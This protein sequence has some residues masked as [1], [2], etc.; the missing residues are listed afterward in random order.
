VRNFG[1]FAVLQE[2]SRGRPGQP[3]DERDERAIG[4]F[5]PQGVTPGDVGANTIS[6]DNARGKFEE[7]RFARLEVGRT[8]E[9]SWEQSEEIASLALVSRTGHVC[10]A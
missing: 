4:Y 7:I 8:R 5:L 1:E 3:R 6:E 9:E 2:D 10:H